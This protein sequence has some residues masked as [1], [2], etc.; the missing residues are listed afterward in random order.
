MSPKEIIEQDQRE[1][2]LSREASYRHTLETEK[3]H[4]KLFAPYGISF[5]VYRVLTYLLLSGGSAAPSQIADDLVILRTNMTNLLNNLEKRNLVERALDPSDRRR[6]IVRILPEGEKLAQKAMAEEKRYG[7]RIMAYISEEDV[8]EYHR[9]EK[10]MY[11]AK[12]AALN[13]IL[14]EREV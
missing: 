9:L 13:D 6:L 2:M 5:S 3:R 4:E 10:R 14:S 1:K 12:V 8:Q 7:Q 11:E